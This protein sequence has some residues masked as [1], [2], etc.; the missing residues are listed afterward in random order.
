[1]FKRYTLTDVTSNQ[2]YQMPKFLFEGELKNN[3]SNDAKVLYSLLKDRH[4]LSVKNNWVNENNEVYLIYTRDDLCDMLGCSPPTLRKTIDQLKKNNLM[5][6]Q[7]QGLNKPNYIFLN[8]YDQ[9]TQLT[10]GAKEFYTPDSKNF[11]L[12]IEKNLPSVP[13]EFCTQECKDFTPNKTNRTQTD[14]SDTEYQSI[15]PQGHVDTIDAIEVIEILK[16]NIGYDISKQT[17]GEAE[18]IDNIVSVMTDALCSS[19]PTIRVGREVKPL[20]VVKS[21]FNKLT[22]EHIQYVCLCLSQN[23]TQIKNIRSYLI[24]ALY[25]APQTMDTYYSQCVKHDMTIKN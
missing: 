18:Y 20:S 4:E 8:Y 19:S 5:D 24:T 7:R 9:Q 12:Q 10:Q 15:Y 11:T 3:L 21:V 17:Q 13:K 6:E 23:T 25:N 22:Y 1:M 16:E 14:F 2:F